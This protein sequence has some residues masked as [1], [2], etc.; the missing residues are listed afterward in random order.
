MITFCFLSP[1]QHERHLMMVEDI[2]SSEMFINDSEAS[3]Q[4]N[5]SQHHEAIR[6]VKLKEWQT[7]S[8][9]FA[10]QPPQQYIELMRAILVLVNFSGSRNN[11]SRITNDPRSSMRLDDQGIIRSSMSLLSSREFAFKLIELD[12][13]AFTSIELNV[14]HSVNLML[15]D[16]KNLGRIIFN[17]N[18]NDDEEENSNPY[19]NLLLILDKKPPK[20]EYEA[21]HIPYHI[22][23]KYLV[24]LQESRGVYEDILRIKIHLNDYRSSYETLHNAEAKAVAQRRDIVRKRRE[25][26]INDIA[27]LDS[28]LSKSEART[29]QIKSIAEDPENYKM[30][31]K[32]AIS[33]I[34]TEINQIESILPYV[35]TD[36]CII[37]TVVVR[38]GWLP[39]NFRQKLLE[40]LRTEVQKSNR[41]VSDSPLLLGCFMDRIQVRHW[42]NFHSHSIPRD[43]SS[44]N[45]MSLAF[46]SPRMTFIVD[47]DG[48][49]DQALHDAWIVYGDVIFVDA[50]S[51]NIGLLES[52]A[53]NAVKK[54]ASTP[55][56]TMGCWNGF[57]VIVT[58]VQAGVSDDLVA[59]L[60]SDLETYYPTGSTVSN[61][62]YPD[63]NGGGGPLDNNDS[64]SAS[65]PVRLSLPP[66]RV[67]LVSSKGPVI[68]SQGRGYPLPPSCFNHMLV[69]HW[70]GMLAPT[71]C[72]DP[73]PFDTVFQKC[74][75][76]D[77]SLESLLTNE[78]CSRLSPDH[79]Q[80][81]KTT[82]DRIFSSSIELHNLENRAINAILNW[83]ETS[84]DYL[85]NKFNFNS[86]KDELRVLNNELLVA[87]NK[88]FLG[89]LEDGEC[90]QVLRKT[91]ENRIVLSRG[92]TSLINHERS[93]L[94]YH[95]SITEVF[96]MSAE[97]L[98]MCSHIIPSHELPPYA[99]SI[100]TICSTSLQ[101][102]LLI[103]DT[104]KLF[105]P[106]PFSLNAAC[107][108]ANAVLKLQKFF[109]SIKEKLSILASLS[110]EYYNFL[111]SPTKSDELD[112]GSIASHVPSRKGSTM[113]PKTKDI[114]SPSPRDS[115]LNTNTNDIMKQIG[116]NRH[117]NQFNQMIESFTKEN[118]KSV[119]SYRKKIGLSATECK[120]GIQV[121]RL[122]LQPLKKMFFHGFIKYM[123]T[124]INPRSEWL[125]KFSLWLVTYSQTHPLPTAELRAFLHLM[126]DFNSTS[127]LT[128]LRE[129]VYP[130]YIPMTRLVIKKLPSNDS[131]DNKTDI[132]SLFIKGG[133]SNKS[134]ENAVLPGFVIRGFGYIDGMLIHNDG[135][136]WKL[137]LAAQNQYPY[138]RA[139]TSSTSHSNNNNNHSRV[140]WEMFID[141]RN[142]PSKLRKALGWALDKEE[143]KETKL[144]DKFEVEWQFLSGVK[145]TLIA[146]DVTSITTNT[147]SLLR[148]PSFAGRELA[149][150]SNDKNA[151]NTTTGSLKRKTSAGS[152][153][154][155]IRLNS[156]N[157]LIRLNSNSNMGAINNPITPKAMLEDRLKN[158]KLR[159]SSVYHGGL[160]KSSFLQDSSFNMFSEE[161]DNIHP[162]VKEILHLNYVY[163]ENKED[164][165]Q[166]LNRLL[167]KGKF[168]AERNCL[169][170]YERHSDLAGVYAG[171]R[172][173]IS[174][175]A[176]NFVSWIRIVSSLGRIMS[177]PLSTADVSFL[178]AQIRPPHPAPRQDNDPNN[179]GTTA[180]QGSWVGGKE[181]SVIQTLLLLAAV[182]P[183]CVGHTVDLLF[184]ATY[185]FLMLGG[186]IVEFSDEIFDTTEAA[187][188]DADLEDVSVLLSSTMDM[189]DLKPGG[190]SATDGYGNGGG[191]SGM[192]PMNARKKSELTL[193]DRRALFAEKYR[194]TSGF[195]KSMKRMKSSESIASSSG[196]VGEDEDIE[197]EEHSSVS[198]D[199][200]EEEDDEFDEDEPVLNES[201]IRERKYSTALKMASSS[202][203]VMSQ[204]GNKPIK[205]FFNVEKVVH[206]NNWT[207]LRRIL[208]KSVAPNTPKYNPIKYE[209]RLYLR[210]F[211]NWESGIIY[212]AKMSKVYLKNVY[213]SSVME[214][215]QKSQNCMILRTAGSAVF[216][217][218]DWVAED[219]ASAQMATVISVS[220]FVS[221]FCGVNST[222]LSGVMSKEA[223]RD[224][225]TR[226]FVNNMIKT[227]KF[228]STAAS[229]TKRYVIFDRLELDS[230][231]GSLLLNA[232]DVLSSKKSSNEMSKITAGSASGPGS[233][234][235]ASGNNSNQ[236][237]AVTSRSGQSHSQPAPVY[238]IVMSSWS[239]GGACTPGRYPPRSVIAISVQSTWLPRCTIADV[240]RIPAPIVLS[241]YLS[242]CPHVTD[243]ECRGIL[244][245][246]LETN[247]LL[248]KNTKNK[249]LNSGRLQNGLKEKLS[250]LSILHEKI[251]ACI[252]VLWKL[253]V[254][255]NGHFRD[256][257]G[258]PSIWCRYHM[259]PNQQQIIRLLLK[260]R[261]LLKYNWLKRLSTD[262]NY[263]NSQ[264]S[265]QNNTTR[266]VLKQS[267]DKHLKNIPVAQTVLPLTKDN[268]FMKYVCLCIESI[269]NLPLRIEDVGKEAS[270]EEDENN[271]VTTPGTIGERSPGPKKNPASI[272][273]NSPATPQIPRKPSNHML[274]TAASFRRNSFRTVGSK[275]NILSGVDAK[276]V[277][278]ATVGITNTKMS[279]GHKMA[280]A[281]AKAAELEEEEEEFSMLWGGKR[282]RDRLIALSTVLFSNIVTDKRWELS[283][284]N[285]N[286]TVNIQNA[287]TVPTI[288]KKTSNTMIISTSS[289]SSL[290]SSSSNM[291]PKTLSSVLK[292]VVPESLEGESWP[293]FRSDRC[294]LSIGG[295]SSQD[296]IQLMIAWVFSS[297]P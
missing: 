139:P 33:Y 243:T 215:I 38:A 223:H 149:A 122:Y 127:T 297:T 171:M 92:I 204:L 206:V 158:S 8:G 150:G 292:D 267:Y 50:L 1:P 3:L 241:N 253:I 117:N 2:H 43:I 137:G 42:T 86:H 271:N 185:E 196:I 66:L 220:N 68:D 4:L 59:F 208:S 108:I 121:L 151:N 166:Q 274:L 251:V 238:G 239:R 5:L 178:I 254:I 135:V 275:G 53:Q 91:T 157:N 125:V 106:V 211:E 15:K 114:W 57:C 12:P 160:R 47:P 18:E 273:G 170:I 23:R 136:L 119:S 209:N 54:D 11:K 115:L 90:C 199:E 32:D 97:F 264:S 64:P 31:F 132:S 280:R 71:Y 266:K 6:G 156:S 58:D 269:L 187:D 113:D 34:T 281:M 110:S 100:S 29:K 180:P 230:T 232:V 261:N 175:F 152:V 248:V 131:V 95:K 221:N 76:P 257:K 9:S 120:A 21:A 30:S 236:Y 98:R 213:T 231:V 105:K 148:A 172:S 83:I 81:L 20:S 293:S 133:S 214:A 63:A 295:L 174:N 116:L 146:N 224:L 16:T 56:V 247:Y 207:M 25:K 55:Q 82:N 173:L 272:E 212:L 22:L 72:M 104:W 155:L 256:L 188:D 217:T 191:T 118:P 169:A 48:T 69:I 229:T 39:E 162:S 282:S 112:S 51:F 294:D 250:L 163:G 260:C 245:Q 154:N 283:L 296:I 102:I 40:D 198:S 144:G 270:T 192:N 10:A 218:V 168:L 80:H 87:L 14:L 17:D 94:L 44:L 216:P 60:S 190:D 61:L 165:A 24:A 244:H 205:K 36:I 153:L 147:I 287:K 124:L 189:F 85:R 259:N 284:M 65:G 109:R 265:I 225:N 195:A 268:I 249:M 45:A 75:G 219:F 276:G 176:S 234:T 145:A 228:H 93:F 193:K 164:D 128:Y 140:R 84:A 49:A 101:N 89:F 78:L 62:G 159:K 237:H 288:N 285:N 233:G 46:L 103:N 141:Q 278:N 52:K 143:K 67:Y 79:L 242:S 258:K 35:V 197:E 88:I 134:T 179:S 289:S 126:N 41:K 99:L 130:P 226:I 96:S 263:I 123:M 142:F 111:F 182:A 279:R 186:V 203:N 73:N 37:A 286:D 255:L 290:I 28:E 167:E 161:I 77:A 74:H 138:H 129:L 107:R 19:K 227:M 27:R 183:E 26:I 240:A 177:V 291:V 184:Q 235:N 7:W 277:S 181:L 222:A 210:D 252:I 200:D 201:I 70:S 246:E 194:K 262:I 13:T 202:S